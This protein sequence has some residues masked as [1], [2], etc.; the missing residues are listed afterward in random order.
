MI[1]YHP[2]T[3]KVLM[4]RILFIAFLGMALGYWYAL[5]FLFTITGVL[6]VSLADIYEGSKESLGSIKEECFWPSTSQGGAV[7]L[8]VTGAGLPIT[9]FSERYWVR[10][11]LILLPPDGI[12]VNM[13]RETVHL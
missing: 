4:E 3:E 5:N 1:I 11:L 2:P 9:C 12:I 10:C 13:S 7:G 6:L 8:Y